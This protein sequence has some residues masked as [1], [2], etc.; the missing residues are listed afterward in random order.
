MSRPLLMGIVN[1]TPD[2]FT[3]DGSLSVEETL[4]HVDAQLAAGADIIDLGAE[5]TRPG[6]A[7]IGDAEEW[8]RLEPILAALAK[9]P[10]RE[11]FL[12]SLDSY[13]APTV[14]KALAFGLDIVNDVSGFRSDAMLQVLSKWDGDI[15]VMHALTVP[16]DPEIVWEP[17]V[18]SVVEILRWKKAILQRAASVDIDPT[19]LI[20]DPGVGFGKTA[21][22][23]LALLA[24][25]DEL[26][27]SGGR[28]LVGHSRKSFLKT[29]LGAEADIDARDDATLVLSAALAQTG[30]HMLRVHNVARHKAMMDGLCM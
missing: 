26:V 24:R 20:F 10:Q 25:V 21:A 15:V 2:S 3:A 12:L 29:V 22:Q 8:Q 13:R 4:A 17:S 9:H 14:A 19:R 5:S 7:V 1:R 27:A 6:A 28:W 18:D 16:A 11:Q 30:V 23:S